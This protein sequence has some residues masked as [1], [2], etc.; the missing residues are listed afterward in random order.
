MATS[1]HQETKTACPQ[2]DLDMSRVEL[3]GLVEITTVEAKD[4]EGPPVKVKAKDGTEVVMHC[5]LNIVSCLIQN[6]NADDMEDEVLLLDISGKNLSKI[7]SYL[8]YLATERKLTTHSFPLQPFDYESDPRIV[9]NFST[10]FVFPPDVLAKPFNM[11]K[12]PSFT[13]EAATRGFME[14]AKYSPFEIN[15]VATSSLDVAHSFYLAASFL[16]IP[17]LERLASIPFGVWAFYFPNRP[18][19]IQAY[20]DIKPELSEKDQEIELTK[21]DEML[22]KLYPPKSDE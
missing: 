16:N 22:D 8:Y 18:K 6:M 13:L 19:V 20:F 3:K 7:D 4:V 14:K 5:L 12:D 10:S 11:S 17:H 15:L 21:I 9:P 1:D 2:D